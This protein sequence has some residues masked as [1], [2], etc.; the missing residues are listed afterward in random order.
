MLGA[1]IGAI[2]SAA[3]GYMNAQASQAN[4]QRNIDL[5]R[6]FAQNAISWKVRDAERAGIHPLYALG[7]STTSFSPVSVGGDP[8][9]AAL[10]G[11]GQ[12]VSRAAAANLP[13]TERA[14]AIAGVAQAQ[15]LEAGQLRNENMMLQNEILKKKVADLVAGTIGPGGPEEKGNLLIPGQ[16]DTAGIK[17]KPLEVAPAGS[18]PSA[19]AGAIT[20]IGYARTTTG[21]APVPSNDVKQRIEDNLPQEI[22]HW[23]RNNILPTFGY[24]LAPPPFEPP[25]GKMWIYSATRQEYQLV[26]KRRSKIYGDEI[27]AGT[28]IR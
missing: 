16:G 15:V 4:A 6:E 25:A 10:A 7:A 17:T 8:L 13:K 27:G 21:W 5:Q 26:D 22:M 3:G 12:D 1:I 23:F 28:Y 24:N 9:G 20:D 11:M 14:N 18:L 19:E 2:A